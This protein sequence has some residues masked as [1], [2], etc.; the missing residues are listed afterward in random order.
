MTK[1]AIRLHVAER[2]LKSGLTLLAV[3]NPGVQ[4]FA[5][6]VSLDTRVADDPVAMPGVAN[7]VGECLDEGTARYDAL[8]LAA[9]AEELGAMLEGNH[10][11]GAIICPATQQQKA[12]DLLRQLVMEPTFPAREVRRVQAEVMTEMQAELDDPRTVAARR[13]RAEIYG[14]HVLGRAMQGTLES[15]AAIKPKH[16]RDYHRTWFRP[17]AGYVAASGPFEPEEMLDR[18]ER[19][20]R[21]LRGAAPEHSQHPEVELGVASDQHLAMPREQVH[22]FL[23]HKGIRRTEPD[24]YKLSVMDHI[25]GSGPGFTSRCSRKLRDEQG[26]CYSV[27]AGISSSAGEEPG[28]FTAYIGT[29]PE[30]RERAVAGFLAEIDAIRK[31]PPSADELQDVKD[32]LTG[33]YV[34]AL[35][36]NSNLAAYAIRARRFGL[37]YDFVERYPDLVRAVTVEDVREV[38]ERHLHPDRL[39]IVSAGAS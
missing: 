34:F 29:S 23:G 28:T 10:R 8:G 22:V 24:F 13:F 30:H 1:A 20:F 25:L 16:L 17:R 32:Y 27:S 9:A 21:G 26:L 3:H 35:E 7:M 31:Q 38:A 12:T 39:T 11:G 37:G 14:D 2:E 4:T 6:A 5:C 19:A 15:V 36:R 33:S 18:L